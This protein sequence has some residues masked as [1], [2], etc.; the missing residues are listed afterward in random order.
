[1]EYVMP[2]R[3][4]LHGKSFDPETIDI[5]NA[6]FLAVCD[7]LG[8]S[9]KT[10]GACEIVAKRVIELM[11]GERDPEEIRKTVLASIKAKASE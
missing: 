7:D 1:V 6:A 9:D 2:I 11:D 8:L 4:F 5:M 10:D 3:A